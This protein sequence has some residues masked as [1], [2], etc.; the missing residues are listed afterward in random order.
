MQKEK[1]RYSI[2]K[3]YGADL[4]LSA[5]FRQQRAESHCRHI[6]GYALGFKLEYGCATLDENGWV[7]NF[8]A[9]KALKE[10]LFAT[11][12]HKML[13]A[14]DDPARS[15]IEAMKQ[16]FDNVNIRV[17]DAVGCEAFAK[18]VFDQADWL[19]RAGYDQSA[20]SRGV[21]IISVECREHGGNS[22]IYYGPGY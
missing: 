16:T 9:L 15:V 12:D 21:H 20:Q 14:R 8:G 11:F 17:V 1:G 3:T 10:W 2:T 22:A 18:L 4:G 6:H 7:Y 13:I 5:T 19:I